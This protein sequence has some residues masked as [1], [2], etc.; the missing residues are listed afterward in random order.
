MRASCIH[1]TNKS[2]IL[3][4]C[5]DNEWL[6]K[7]A[8]TASARMCKGHYTFPH[9]PFLMLFHLSVL[10]EALILS[11]LPPFTFSLSHLPTNLLYTCPPFS[12]LLF[13]YLIHIMAFFTKG[14]Q[15]LLNCFPN[16]HFILTTIL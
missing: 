15:S 11:S 3:Q 12:A 6:A 8:C 4:R 16:F 2:I 7:T 5:M 13:I 14:T 1:S 9:I 10:L